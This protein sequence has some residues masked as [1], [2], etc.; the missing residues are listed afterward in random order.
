MIAIHFT[1]AD[2][3]ANGIRL[4]AD[5]LGIAVTNSAA[6]AAVWITV[7]KKASPYLRVSWDGT[8]ANI[9]YG[10][11]RA[12]FFRALGLLCEAVRQG[13]AAFEKEEIPAF[14]SNGPMFDMSRNYVMNPQTVKAIL[15][16][17]A[18]MGLNL[19]MLYTEDTYAVEGRPYFGH[20]RGRYTHEELRE[21]DAY[22]QEL[23]I[24][25]IPC[26]QFL[27]H[28][29]SALQWDCMKSVRDTHE[30][31]CID[32]PET[33][34]LIDDMM[35]S[36]SQCFTS[37]RLHMG[38]DESVFLGH[39]QY[40][41]RHAPA[42][43]TELFCRHLNR[44]RDIAKTYGFE[45]MMWSDMFFEIASEKNTYYDPDVVFT[46]A[47]RALVPQDVSQVYWDYDHEDKSFY[48]RMIA[49]HR[50]LTPH[51]VFAGGIW[52]WL[53]PA[54]LY[55]KTVATTVP[56][57]TSCI[58][59]HVDT[60]IATVWNNGAE[61][62][63]ITALYGLQLFAEMDYTRACDEASLR[64]R[65]AFCCG[66]DAGALLAME[67]ANDPDGNA[68]GVTNPS[69]YL[70]WNDPLAGLMD[71]HVGCK[72]PQEAYGDL[73]REFASR[74]EAS[75]LFAPAL[76][77]F[78][79]VLEVLE[80]KADYGV[81]LKAA[82]EA[83]NMAELRALYDLAEE[84]QRRIAALR[85]AHRDAWYFYNKS[86]GFELMDMMYGALTNRFD[87]VRFELNRLFSDP[88]YRI[89]QLE[90]DRLPFTGDADKNASPLRHIHAR[91]GR[92]YTAN[93]Y[94]TTSADSFLG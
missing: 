93:V 57:L 60:V 12:R 48:D 91:F 55:T 31:L 84:I 53:G 73:A 67:R 83:R 38:M 69:R 3:L 92:I 87:T 30:V 19:F 15:R 8:R 86:F 56:A 7:C 42:P 80:Y 59:N 27:G 9:E 65:F 13:A 85:L 46:D 62:S 11:G 16:K 36:L 34:A 5:D 28:L 18:L 74:P 39:G 23:G 50:E 24:E 66:T 29:A 37:R 22:A 89:A 76:R 81:R 58:Q 88:E 51:T 43:Q 72:H 47:V 40:L 70:L 49:K 2:E 68:C 63:L 94:A 77:Q 52:T 20:M 41:R 35:R 1:G 79:R 54:P 26:V 4:L 90:E 44:I 71:A 75:P 78:Q 82:Y 33:Y 32:E 17:C 64:A 25:L 10:G 6:Q 61:G 21:L 45:L 14:A